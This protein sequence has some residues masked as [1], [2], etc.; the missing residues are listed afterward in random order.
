MADVNLTFP[1]ASK[2]GTPV[3]TDIVTNQPVTPVVYHDGSVNNPDPTIATATL[4]TDGSL[5]VVP[6]SPGTIQVQVNTLAD[7][8]DSTGT[9]VTGAAVPSDPFLIIVTAAQ[10]ADGVKLSFVFA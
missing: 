5:S 10:T 4:N 3:L 8:T 9:A 6:L 1:G 7:F 2:K